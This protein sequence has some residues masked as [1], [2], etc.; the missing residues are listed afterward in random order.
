MRVGA[1]KLSSFRPPFCTF[2]KHLL[3]SSVYLLTHGHPSSLEDGLG[4]CGVHNQ[5]FQLL[6]LILSQVLP[7][8]YETSHLNTGRK[9]GRELKG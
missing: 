4:L 2:K 9:E 5:L 7:R 8:T 1:T 3:H 6:H